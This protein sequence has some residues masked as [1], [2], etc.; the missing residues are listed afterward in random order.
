MYKLYERFGS[1]SKKLISRLCDPSSIPMTFYSP[2][3]T[4]EEIEA[5][6]KAVRA[7]KPAEPYKCL[8]ANC[9]GCSDCDK[10]PTQCKPIPEPKPK[11]RRLFDTSRFVEMNPRVVALLKR[12][13]SEKSTVRWWEPC[14]GS[15]AAK[16]VK[17]N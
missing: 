5:R 17:I 9:V 12:D 13:H 7:L 6:L 8:G 2:P 11:K 16:R 15:P 4:K 1:V 3:R 10:P 14:E